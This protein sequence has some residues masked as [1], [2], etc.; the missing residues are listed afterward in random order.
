MVGPLQKQVLHAAPKRLHPPDG[1][2]PVDGRG[3]LRATYVAVLH[4]ERRE[5]GQVGERRD[6]F[7]QPPD[8]IEQPAEVVRQ[9]IFPAEQRD[10]RLEA[11]LRGLLDVESEDLVRNPGRTAR[12]PQDADVAA[13]HAQEQTG[14]IDVGPGRADVADAGRPAADDAR[15]YRPRAPAASRSFAYSTRPSRRARAATWFR[16]PRQRSISSRL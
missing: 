8:A 9:R 16:D 10:P 2:R 11:L 1:V 13:G 6:G 15:A 5:A 3:V 4:G 14:L 7:F 12:D